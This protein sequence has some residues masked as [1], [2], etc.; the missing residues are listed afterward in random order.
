[1]RKKKKLRVRLRGANV[2]VDNGVLWVGEMGLFRRR[3]KE[4]LIR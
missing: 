2:Y 3:K 4:N 1:M